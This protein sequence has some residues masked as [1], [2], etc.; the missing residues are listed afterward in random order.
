LVRFP[1][2]P[3]NTFVGPSSLP[4][5]D[6]DPYAS[7][8]CPRDLY[9]APFTSLPLSRH[10]IAHPAGPGPVVLRRARR[11][12][13]SPSSWISLIVTFRP[14]SPTPETNLRSRLEAPPTNFRFSTCTELRTPPR[15]GAGRRETGATRR[16]GAGT[17]NVCPAGERMNARMDGWM[18]PQWLCARGSIRP[19]TLTRQSLSCRGR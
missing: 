9:P 7:R 2:S 5:G 8:I 4:T 18:D 1:T 3:G 11:H 19:R 17:P 12:S 16:G 6:D 13:V 14:Y 10:E 15:T